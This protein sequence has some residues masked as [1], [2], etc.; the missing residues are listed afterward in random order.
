MGLEGKKILVSS[1]PTMAPLDALRFIS[2]T[3]TGR[4]GREIASELLGRGASVTFLYGSGSL[5]PEEGVRL[6]EVKTVDEL[7]SAVQ[8]LKD[9]RFDAILHAM[10][11]LDFAPERPRQGKV[12]SSEGEWDIRL[13]RTPK[14]LDLMREIWP[15]A[16]LVGFKLEVGKTREELLKI[17]RDFLARSR[18]D[19]VVANDLGDISG[20]R[21]VAYLVSREAGGFAPLTAGLEAVAYTKKEIAIRL[22]DLLEKVLS[23][24]HGCYKESE[25]WERPP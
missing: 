11:V 17:A 14:V 22:A 19:L 15:D 10:A 3:S 20:E 13:V 21:H 4:L 1:G 2:N 23:V 24:R 25:L 8:G 9:E 18:A 16:F 12:S 6:V 7:Q 5:K